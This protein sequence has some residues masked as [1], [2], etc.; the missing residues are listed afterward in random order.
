M[1]VTLRDV[2]AKAGVSPVVVSRVLHNKALSVGVSEST[3][4][5][6]RQAARSLGYRRNVAAINFRTQQTMAIG[7]LHGIGTIMPTLEGGTKYFAALMDGFVA[8]AF[9]HGYSLLLC[10]TLLGT[11]PDDAMNDGRCDGLILYNVEVTETNATMLQNCSLPIVLVH[12]RGQDFGGNILSVICD[13]R[14]GI[15]LALEHLISL[16]HRKIAYAQEP[17]SETYEMKERRLAF[18]SLGASLDLDVSESDVIGR[19]NFDA[20]FTG[21]YTGIIACHDGL[22][23]DIVVSAQQRGLRVPE[24]LSVVGFDSTSYCLEIDPELTSVSQPLQAMGKEAVRLLIARISDAPLDNTEV[25]FPCQLDI[26]ASTAVAKDSKQPTK[27]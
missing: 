12:T 15:Q 11:N 1:A 18:L 26:R 9:D 16:G 21:E 27:P 17:W 8:G 13:N 22:A 5:R 14:G 19:D 7:L 2:A 10:P 3:A 4:I 23:G 6:V 25:M 24:E 20:L